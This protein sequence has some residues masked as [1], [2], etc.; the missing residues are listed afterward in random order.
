[1][2]KTPGKRLRAKITIPG[3]DKPI[4]VS[5]HSRKELEEKKRIVRETYVD[6]V[7]PRDLTFHQA[8]IE[9]YTSIKRPR[10]RSAGTRSNYEGMINNH[11]LPC[12]PDQ[13]LVR[14]IRRKDLQACVDLLEGFSLNSVN[15]CMSIL[16]HSM[17]Y[18]V[19]ENAI[20]S[21]PASLLVRPLTGKPHDKDA[22]TDA[23]RDAIFAAAD[24]SP[25]GRIVYILYY[26]GVRIGEALG[27]Q[28]GDFD[29]ENELVH[30]QRDIDF[31]ASNDGTIGSVKNDTSDRFVPIPEPLKE[32][33]WP[34]RGMPSAFV[35]LMPDGSRPSKSQYRSMWLSLMHAAGLTTLKSEYI[36]DRD[37]ALAL[38]LKP[39]T[40]SLYTDYDVLIT[41]HWFRHNF[42]TL[43]FEAGVDPVTA[44]NI[45]GHSNYSTTANVYTHLKEKQLRKAAVKMDAVFA[46]GCQKVAIF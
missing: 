22:L 16:R 36:E 18:A 17:E 44:M 23:Q 42:A 12:F 40:P 37:S 33:L 45:L 19:T 26:L 10:I 35:I 20:A 1:M 43:L 41:A 25:D 6:G 29:W 7:K 39:P 38:G 21:S 14:T 27:L 4:W 24:A 32:H 13:R 5:A 34:L 30:I 31:T 2:A 46:K 28:W 8:V 3:A 15:L 11:I 9:W